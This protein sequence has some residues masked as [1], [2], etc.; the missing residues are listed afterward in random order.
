MAFYV[1]ERVAAEKTFE[2]ASNVIECLGVNLESCNTIVYTVY[3]TPDSAAHR[4]TSGE[5]KS[6]LKK[7]D[8]H[9]KNLP[10]PTP[11]IVIQGDFNLPHAIW[12]SDETAPNCPGDEKKMIRDLQDV[13]MN[14]FLVQLIEGATHQGGNLLD[15]VFTNCSD[16]IHSWEATPCDNEVS[17][18]S[19][20]TVYLPADN[21][22]AKEE[23][24]DPQEPTEA[25][26]WRE[27]NFF[28]DK[29][30]WEALNTNISNHDWAADS[31]NLDAETRLSKLKQRL[32]TICQAAIPRRKPRQAGSKIP[33]DRRRL[34]RLRARARKRL[35]RCTNPQSKAACMSKLTDIQRQLRESA[36]KQTE[37]EEATAV[38]S[39]KKN[40]K[41]FFTYAKRFLTTRTNIGPLRTPEKTLTNS[42]KRMADLLAKQYQEA[43]SVPRM[44]GDL[45]NRIFGNDQ[46]PPA[47]EN[48]PPGL[49][50][51][52]FSV[53]NLR[54]CMKELRINSAAGPDGVPAILL[55]K[56]ADS[57]APPLAAMW[58]KSMDEGAVPQSLKR[59]VITPIH[60]GKSKAIPKNYRPVA[61]TS[62]ICK[63]FEK[64][65]RRRIAAYLEEN[66]LF[67]PGQH[68]F[69]AGRSC[70][71]QLLSHLDRITA[72]LEQGS[73]V[74]VVYLD[75]SKAFD[76]VDI[77]ITLQKLRDLGIGG[78]LGAWLT[79]F[80]TGRTQ[81]VSVAG[82][83]S[84]QH[85]V[86]SGVPQGSVLGPL[87][88]LVLLGNIDSGIV[89]SFVSSFA[90][91][92]RV[93]CPITSVADAELLQQDLQLIYS[94][95]EANNMEFNAE[96]FEM[97]RYQANP[98]RPLPPVT[99]T[100]PDGAAIDEKASVRDLGVTL[101]NTGCF[102]EHIADR[103]RV[104]RKL[105]G[106]VLRTFKTRATHTMLTLWKS[107]LLCHLEYCS[108]LWSP[109]SPG[110]IQAI[111]ELQRHYLKHIPEL[112]GLSYW[113]MLKES[114]LYSLQR[115]RERYTIIYTWRMLE[116]QVP[117]LQDP[118]T[119]NWHVRRGRT[120]RVPPVNQRLPAS[121]RS[122]R[123][124]SIA[125]RG[126][127]LFNTLPL[128]LRNLTECTSDAFKAALDRH[129]ATVP[130]EPLVPG[131]TAFRRAESNS[132]LAWTERVL[133][134]Q[135][136]RVGPPD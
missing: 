53:L 55:N 126:P 57:L 73:G 14:H 96:K 136:P 4:S 99:I 11:N 68:G 38:S 47:D 111:E 101:S 88:F 48:Q 76:K 56:C 116:G 15:L 91:D 45:G 135:A 52:D 37:K 134:D 127:S 10:T 80:L 29:V 66:H 129:L 93:G 17:D 124:S 35:A 84:A 41:Y 12:E 5:F 9:I 133:R 102:S 27:L 98:S 78:K 69:R 95:C 107:F 13:A 109:S 40:S 122:A 118:I 32:L 34:M 3:R 60:K 31:V 113:E 115:R 24:E 46:Q 83:L 33:P 86:I 59:A 42:P 123:E 18:H 94:W 128:E 120:C 36:Q 21:T 8:E 97:L 114:K 54:D 23:I 61:L 104:V 130:D 43:F 125:I 63:V 110:E 16:R 30:D 39:I 105:T 1:S 79:S 85:P 58:R 71:S 75:F 26:P 7:L 89:H 100:A 70:L 132:L 64:V 19:H 2:Y 82:R 28:S 6:F 44:T 49:R 62:Q 81:A 74:D 77:G 90:D 67:N 72:L 103:V 20:I 108:Q 50:D 51:I 22:L 119:S 112:R 87:L 121:I 65:V 25:D 92:T 117:N 106:W 131:L